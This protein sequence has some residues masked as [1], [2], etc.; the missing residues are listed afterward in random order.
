MVWFCVY[1]AIMGA[2]LSDPL[3]RFLEVLDKARGGDLSTRVVLN[4]P[5]RDE[6]GRVADGINN[7][8]TTLEQKAA[9]A[10]EKTRR[11]RELLAQ[12]A[13]EEK[14]RI[15]QE[16]R[17]N[18]E[19]ADRERRRREE[20][21]R[22]EEQRIAEE[23]RRVEA[24]HRQNEEIRR[25]VDRLLTVVTAAAQGDLTHEVQVEGNQAVDELASGIQAMLRDLSSVLVQVTESAHQFAEGAGAIGESSQELA[26]GAQEQTQSVERMRDAV[27]R[28]TRSIEAVRSNAD[29]AN[30]VASETNRLAQQGDAASQ[31]ALEAMELIRTSSEQITEIIQVVSDIAGQTNLLALNAAIEAARAGEHGMGFAVVAD[32]VRKLAERSNQAAHQITRLI[33]ESS[34]RVQEGVQLNQQSGENLRQ[35]IEGVERTA[36]RIG[37]IASATLEQTNAAD[38]VTRAIESVTAIT[39]RTASGS[40]EMAASGEELG[41]QAGMLRA[42]VSR[43]RTKS[44]HGA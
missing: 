35:I 18:A 27:A 13:E 31:K 14:A 17:R 21:R 44:Q 11:E 3:K 41:S 33:R 7:L 5:R 8:L 12:Q 9:E 42:L 15:E 2:G 34:N 19:E 24:E 20:E 32:E 30:R 43:F 23:H 39:E 16:R 6:L 29:E 40:E 10:A 37:A 1:W 26:Q 28:L 38:E 36:Q 4:F 25:K 22:F